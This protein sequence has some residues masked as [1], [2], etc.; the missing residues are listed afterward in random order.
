VD[1]D[2]DIAFY[3]NA[4]A[5]DGWTVTPNAND[6]VHGADPTVLQTYEETI[7]FT[8]FVSAFGPDEDG[9]W[10]FS[11]RDL[12]APAS[13]TYCFRAVFLDDSLLLR[14]QRDPGNRYCTVRCDRARHNGK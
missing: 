12:S 4:V 6:P 9:M 5:V 11:L 13:T 14:L 2:T 1:G 3:N 10:D 8:N 7:E